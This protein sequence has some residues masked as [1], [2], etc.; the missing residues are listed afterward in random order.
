MPESHG[1]HRFSLLYL[2]AEGVAAFQALYVAN[3]LAP[4]AIGIIQPGYG[5]GGNW[6]D[7]TD[8]DRIFAGIVLDN[9]AGH[10]KFLLHGGI[11]PREFYDQPCWPEYS[12]QRGFLD[13]AGGGSIGV[14]AKG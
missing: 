3:Q 4:A 12:E 9:P 5:F 1:P 6:T 2:C 11:G 14:W 8:R 7:F 10:P 13:K